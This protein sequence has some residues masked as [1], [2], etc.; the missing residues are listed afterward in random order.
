MD[1]LNKPEV[2]G[3]ADEPIEAGQMVE[4]VRVNQFGMHWLRPLVVGIATGAD[5]MIFKPGE[6]I[7]I[8]LFP[9][10]NRG[11]EVIGLVSGLILGDE[12]P[13]PRD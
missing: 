7:G 8:A 12:P 6:P 11:D 10:R 9:A 5:T 4:I 13:L 2:L 1:K 3:Y